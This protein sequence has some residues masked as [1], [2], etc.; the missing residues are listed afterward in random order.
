MIERVERLAGRVRISASATGE[1]RQCRACG[2]AS[3]RVHSRYRRRVAD[4]PI[5]GAPVVIELG[6]RRF[7]CEHV[8]CS[9]RTFVEQIPQL[10]SRYARRSLG[11]ART[12]AAVGLALAGRAGARLGVRLGLPASRS[13]L[14]RLVEQLPDPQVG[15]V[16]V[17][18]DD[19]ALRRGH[20][21]GTVR[22]PRVQRN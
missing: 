7:F 3:V 1:R 22:K 8:S 17:L 16:A 21:Y 20:V 4:A 2:T 15:A 11:L 5:S 10:T 18:V 14:L 6:V 9:K 12:L 13:T 19:F